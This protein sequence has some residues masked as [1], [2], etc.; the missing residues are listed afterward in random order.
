MLL[1]LQFLLVANQSL[2]VQGDTAQSTETPKHRIGGLAMATGADGSLPP[3][4]VAPQQAA[5]PD[6]QRR[7]SVTMQQIAVAV[8]VSTA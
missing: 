7:Q 1:L 8:Q 6:Q 2:Y 4:A 5:A 3:I